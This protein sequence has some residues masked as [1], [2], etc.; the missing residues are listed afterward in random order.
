VNNCL[1]HNT[2]LFSGQFFSSK[3]HDMFVALHCAQDVETVLCELFKSA[4]MHDKAEKAEKVFAEPAS[5]S[6][7][8]RRQ[9]TVEELFKGESSN[10]DQYSAS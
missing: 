1:L 4:E 5:D 8:Y 2:V 9:L 3:I 6:K 10:I 7:S